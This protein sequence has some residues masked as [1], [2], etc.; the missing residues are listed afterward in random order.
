V[1]SIQ[2][3]TLSQRVI[4]ELPYAS[5]A[6]R[7]DHPYRVHVEQSRLTPLLLD[8]LAGFPHAEVRFGTTVL[9]VRQ[10]DDAVRVLVR[11]PSGA[12]LPVVADHV[13]AADGSR[14]TVRTAL[15]LPSRA[16][17]YPTFA[18]RVVTDTPLDTLVPGLSPLAY[19]RDARQSFSVLGMPDHW[20][21]IFRLPAG[22]DRELAVDR[23][24]VRELVRRS[25]PGVADQVR[26]TDAHTYRLASFVLPQ[27]R[28]GRVLFAGDAAHL[29]STAGGMNMNCGLHDA[30]AFGRTLAAVHTGRLA[31][32]VLA[33]AAL[34]DTAATRRDAVVHAVLPRSEARTAGLG[35]PAGLQRALDDIGRVAADP[36]RTTDYLVKA[37]LLDCAPQPQSQPQSQLSR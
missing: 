27:Y 18:L 8:A 11:T 19:I 3:R 20:R 4:H 22:G 29:T 34:T 31:D 17:T 25:L 30:V 5:L 1:D 6:G 12:R 15:H 14:S 24:H 10:Q 2:W 32:P 28:A 36:D 13:L 23:D 21:M 16:T 37:S 7:T 26:V 33:D 9:D 35:D